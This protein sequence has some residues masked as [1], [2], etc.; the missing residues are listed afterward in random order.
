MIGHIR[1]LVYLE[2]ELRLTVASPLVEFEEEPTAS[3]ISLCCSQGG[4]V[5]L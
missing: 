3:L 1:L 4:K 5:R 2:F